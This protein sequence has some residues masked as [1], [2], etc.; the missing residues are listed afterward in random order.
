MSG[1]LPDGTR[2]ASDRWKDA[3]GEPCQSVREQPQAESGVDLHEA[4]RAGKIDNV[5][6]GC[7]YEACEGLLGKVVEMAGR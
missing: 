6:A 2:A 1:F 7:G 4:R 3:L 5:Q